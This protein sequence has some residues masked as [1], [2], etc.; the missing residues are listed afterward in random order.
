MFIYRRLVFN[1][2]TFVSEQDFLEIRKGTVYKSLAPTLSSFHF[3]NLILFFLLPALLFFLPYEI[4]I[5][6]M[7]YVLTKIVIET[8]FHY[9]YISKEKKYHKKLI[10]IANRFSEYIEFYNEYERCFFKS[11]IGKIITPRVAKDNESLNYNLLNNID[12]I[13]TE[14]TRMLESKTNTTPEVK[15]WLLSR[16][17]NE[18]KAEVITNKI[19]EKL[20]KRHIQKRK[21]N[22]FWGIVILFLGLMCCYFLP[23]RNVYILLI[24]IGGIISVKALSS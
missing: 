22:V 11:K 2:P 23:V 12:F 21:W 24:L 10:L 14:A 13:Y 5:G 20:H 4:V 19:A 18:E 8:Y 1:I 16:G 7:G 3:I 6:L 9:D 17:L 15:E